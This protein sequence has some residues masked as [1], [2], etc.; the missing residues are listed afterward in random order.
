MTLNKK[1][2]QL[3]EFLKDKKIAICYSGG[4]DSTLLA[5]IAKE[6]SKDVLLISF[7]NGVMPRQFLREVSEAAKDLELPHEIIEENFFN[8]E[9]FTKNES[10]RCYLC[11]E[12]MYSKMKVLA[13]EKGYETLLDGNNISDLLEDRPGIIAKHNNNIISPL[14][15]C[16]FQSSDVYEYLKN[17]NIDYLKSTTCLATR[18]QTNTP[19]TKKKINKIKTSETLIQNLS[20]V[21]LV[22][23][24]DN[25]GTAI[26]E[27][28][29]IKPL[30]NEKLLN[31]IDGELKA[32]GFKKVTLNISPIGLN[33]DGDLLV[34]KPCQKE[35]N[36][37]MIEK[38]LPYQINVEKTVGELEKISE[39][40]SSS[41][42]GV[43]M[44]KLKGSNIN[45]F[46]K[47]KIVIRE[48]ETKEE[49]QEILLNI[50]PKIRRTLKD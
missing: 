19:I 23:V 6:V 26:C 17:N 29:D 13:K 41:N 15:D 12:I 48:I 9:N 32:I 24:R 4:S 7:N 2:S 21:E 46:K 35:D 1:I 22:K 47:G 16:G 25:N 20:K 44:L 28:D 36:K 11:R 39:V 14:I 30:L 43:I 31:T 40:K 27:C 33:S 45:I 34:Y 10:T 38:I 42:M 8:N 5:N 3:K 37:I 49:G 18:I 50:L